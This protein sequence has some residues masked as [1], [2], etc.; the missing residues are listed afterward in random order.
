MFEKKALYQKYRPTRIQDIIGQ[1]HIKQT[2]INAVKQDKLSHAYLFAGL[3]GTGKT[4][5]ARIMA[6]IV[7]C[8]NAPSVDYT[9]D[10]KYI[11]MINE[12]SFPD[13]RELD[14]ASNSSV[15]N[16]RDIIKD[17]YNIPMMGQKKVF[18]IDECQILKN[19]S[20]AA[21]LKTLEE[22]PSHAMFILCT[23]DPQKVL[24]TIHS[25]CQRFQFRK[26]KN[27]EI[28]THLKMICKQEGISVAQDSVLEAV[29]KASGGSV[30]DALSSFDAILSRCGT[31]V[32][33]TE[34]LDILGLSGQD[35]I[36]IIVKALF[37]EDYRAAIIRTGNLVNGS[38][39]DPKDVTEIQ[40]TK[41]SRANTRNYPTRRSS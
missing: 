9:D 15:E 23:T 32:T 37:K 12:G 25:R 22:P 38:G 28:V 8:D 16:L 17:A 18:I 1:E 5:L 41:R 33:E 11:K 4:S 20:L 31:N 14:A 26:I 27:S 21:I 3:R 35:Q 40:T 19:N 7:N 2:I 39:K 24:P 34:A 30:R 10:D 36:F 29:A 6:R 13:I